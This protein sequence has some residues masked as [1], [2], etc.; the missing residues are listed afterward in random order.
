MKLKLGLILILVIM[1]TGLILDNE[2]ERL[3]DQLYLRDSNGVIYGANSIYPTKVKHPKALVFIHGFADTPQVFHQL[4]QDLTPNLHADIYAPLL[5]FHGRNLKQLKNLN[6]TAVEHFIQAELNQLS[7]HYQ[8]VYVVAHSYAGTLLSRLIVQRKLT[9]NIHAILYA[10]AI[11]IQ[12]NTPIHSFKNH[13]YTLWRNY[14]NYAILGCSRAFRAS[15]DERA[16]MGEISL[17]YKVVPA[18]HRL[19]ELDRKS[20]TNISQIKQPFYLIIAKDD[21]RVE[22]KQVTDNCKKNKPY[23]QL[24][25]L[26][27]G[28]HMPHYGK[29][30]ARFE[31][32]LISII[33]AGAGS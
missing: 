4:I 17:Q 16:Q 33:S 19:F 5:P 30:K 18:I 10:P 1:L 11:F 26:D 2:A 23:C 25:L 7:Q 13:L 14:C 22:S 31:R 27:Q 32:L 15:D 29:N 6:N 3:I 24:I 8:E 9:A 20:R 21:S 12:L 28:K